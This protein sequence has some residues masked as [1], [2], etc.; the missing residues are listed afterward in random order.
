MANTTQ[1]KTAGRPAKTTEKKEVVSKE[2]AEKI[3][4]IPSTIES[5]IEQVKTA[6]ADVKFYSDED[7][8]IVASIKSGR[9]NL[10]NDEKPYDEYIWEKFG[11]IQEVRFGRLDTLRRKSGEEVFKTMLYVLD[12]QAVK[13]LRLEKVYENIGDLVKLEKLFNLQADEFI[14]FVNNAP[15]ITKTILR[16]LLFD[17]IE[18]KEDI[19]VFNLQIW[20]EKLDMDFDIKDIKR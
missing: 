2:I 14:R 16:E 5:K 20:A 12:E 8:V 18:R 3:Q 7:M 6:K 15:E 11:D 1:K 19:N 17:K 10:Y 13:Q 9:T 4:D